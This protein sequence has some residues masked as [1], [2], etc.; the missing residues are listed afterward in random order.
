MSIPCHYLEV[1]VVLLG[2]ALLLAEAFFPR[3]DKS[4]LGWAACAGLVAIFVHLFFATNGTGPEIERFYS[5]DTS[6]RFFKGFALVTTFLVT[7]MSLD[8]RKVLARFTDHPGSEQG[9]GEFYALP[10]F[11]C[12]GMM[13]MASAKDLVMAFVA[14]AVSYTHLTLPTIYSV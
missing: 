8:Y 2:V 9:T 3:E 14:L 5:S 11:A 6:A 7:L 12:A 1:L 4:I 10:L 13:W